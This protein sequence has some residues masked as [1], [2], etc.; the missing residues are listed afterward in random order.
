MKKYLSLLL[1][2]ISLSVFAQDKTTTKLYIVRHAEKMTDNPKER[3]PLLTSIG[4][5]RAEALAQLM[6]KKNI[7]AIYATDYKRTNA[8]AQP[9]ASSQGLTIQLYDSKNLKAAIATI[10]KNNSG[11]NVLIVG[12]SN[13]ILET[14]EAT[15]ALKPFDSIG[16]NDYN[17][18]FIVTLKKN[19]NTK[20]RVMKYG[21]D[22]SVE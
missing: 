7:Q 16:D 13:T 22:N 20:V 14:I 21:A 15:G 17:N 9:T 2:L 1:V 10:L 11:K 8:T 3:D 19:G 5:E 4:T 12:H 18:L 6:R